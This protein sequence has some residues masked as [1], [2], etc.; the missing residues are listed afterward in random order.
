LARQLADG[1]WNLEFSLQ[2]RLPEAQRMHIG[3]FG[4]DKG[5]VVIACQ[6]VN[7]KNSIYIDSKYKMSLVV[8]DGH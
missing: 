8:I 4:A 2:V 6:V 5:C 3:I 1:A 7:C